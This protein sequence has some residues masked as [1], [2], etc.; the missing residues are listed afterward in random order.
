MTEVKRDHRYAVINDRKYKVV[1]THT[2]EEDAVAALEGQGYVHHS[3]WT[4][5]NPET[6]DYCHV[7]TVDQFTRDSAVVAAADRAGMTVDAYLQL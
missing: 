4:Y 7:S 6:R 3:G 1:S 5:R 2:T